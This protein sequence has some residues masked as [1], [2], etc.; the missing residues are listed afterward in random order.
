MTKAPAFAAL[1][2]GLLCVSRPAQSTL[3]ASEDVLLATRDKAAIALLAC[4]RPLASHDAL[5]AIRLTGTRE[6]H[7]DVTCESTSQVQ[8]LP[9]LRVANCNNAAGRW[10]CESSEAVRMQLAGKDVVLSYDS[11]MEL[12]TVLEVANFAASVRSFN[13]YDVAAIMDGQCY[14]GG[15]TSV[16]FEGAVSYNIGCGNWDGSITKDCGGKQCRLF[17]TQLGEILY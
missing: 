2:A 13:G 1:C 4:K 14:V 3:I 9:S 15:G 8:G 17:F 10:S 12:S 5:K 11:S 7:V 16:P 6:I